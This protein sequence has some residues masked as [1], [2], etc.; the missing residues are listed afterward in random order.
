MVRILGLSGPYN[1]CTYGVEPFIDALVSP[2]D[3]FNIVNG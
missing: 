2:I 1:L 3:L